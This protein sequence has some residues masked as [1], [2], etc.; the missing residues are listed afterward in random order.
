MVNHELQETLSNSKKR[1][2]SLSRARTKSPLE[3]NQVNIET[4][5]GFKVEKTAED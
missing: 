1:M 2:R 3:L 4:K 5:E